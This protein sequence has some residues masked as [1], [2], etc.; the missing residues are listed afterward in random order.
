MDLI[1]FKVVSSQTSR[2]DTGSNAIAVDEVF[3]MILGSSFRHIV[4][5]RLRRRVYGLAWEPNTPAQDEMLTI[6]PRL[7]QLAS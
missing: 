5:G 7:P 4:N 6:H 2:N 1:I 3:S